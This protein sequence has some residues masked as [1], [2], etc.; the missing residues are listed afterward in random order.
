MPTLSK[1]EIDR[2]LAKL[3]EA[4]SEELDSVGREYF[5]LRSTGASWY[6]EAIRRGWL[7]GP[8]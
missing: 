1:S 5:S 3:S 8:A 4:Q 6:Q 7:A 2:E